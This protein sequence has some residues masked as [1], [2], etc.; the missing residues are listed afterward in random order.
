MRWYR[1]SLPLKPNPHVG[2]TSESRCAKDGGGA[3]EDRT[4]L[5]SAALRNPIAFVLTIARSATP[6]AG[7]SPQQAVE[8]VSPNAP[9]SPVDNNSGLRSNRRLGKILGP[10]RAYAQPGIVFVRV[11]SFAALPWHALHREFSH[12]AAHV[13]AYFR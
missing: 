10:K 2:G 11:A 3:G 9:G 4:H 6:A 7:W 12:H 5:C 1:R 13:A 8:L